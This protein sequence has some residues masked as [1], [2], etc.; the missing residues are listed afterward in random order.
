LLLTSPTAE[1][2]SKREVSLNTKLSDS[3]RGRALVI[4]LVVTLSVLRI[5]SWVSGQIIL[6]YVYGWGRVSREHLQ[7]ARLKPLLVVSNGDVLPY[8][9]FVHYLIGVAIWMPSAILLLV[10]A[11]K[12]LPLPYHH[13]MKGGAYASWSILSI[14]F[15][16]FA[17]NMLPLKLA[18]LGAFILLAALFLTARTSLAADVET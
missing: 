15:L 4:W 11:F 18:L 8:S 10:M 9:P 5:A 1:E 13:A 16:F 17:L 12:L 3:L 2:G 6:I 14:I 7:M